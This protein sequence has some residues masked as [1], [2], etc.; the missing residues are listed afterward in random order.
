[1]GPPDTSVC[2]QNLQVVQGV[3]QHL[4]VPLAEEKVEGPSTSLTFL[5]ILLDT[6]KME[7]CL[8][9]DKLQRI[10]SQVANWLGRKKAKKRQIL[11]LVGLLQHAAKVIKPGHTFIARMYK[12]ATKL[13]KAPS[14]NKT[15]QRFQDRP[16]TLFGGKLEWYQLHLQSSC[17]RSI[18]L[19]PNQ[20][21][22]LLGVRSMP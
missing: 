3:C 18:A 14:C 22:G 5:G 12:A 2:L 20:R 8:P 17:L 6:A 1:M 7:A 9:D 16:M 21:L 4:G 13:Q 11:Y 10:H 19:Y 15:Y